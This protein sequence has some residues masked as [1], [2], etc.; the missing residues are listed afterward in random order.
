MDVDLNGLRPLED[1]SLRSAAA[2]SAQLTTEA[3]AL[4]AEC[5]APGTF[6]LRFAASPDQ[7]GPDYGLL[8]AKPSPPAQARFEVDAGVFRLTA[9]E[10]SLEL[11]PRPVRLRLVRGG[12][13]LLESTGDG[14]IRGGLRIPALATETGGEAWWMALGLSSC[15]PVYG[16]GEKF[17]PL[18]RRSQLIVSWNEDALGT[19]TERSYKNAPFAWSPKGWGVFVHTTAR[20]VHGVGYPQWSQRS[21]IVRV[22][23]PVLDVF[24][25]TG[26]SPAEILERYTHLVGRPPLLPRWSYGVWMSRC[27]YRTA[28]EAMEAAR[29]LRERR[30]PADVLVLDGRAWLKVET[31][32]AFEWDR[33]RYP[34]PAAFAR[35]LRALNFRLCVW[36]YP[37][38][39]VHHPLFSELA[40]KGYL[41]RTGQGDPYVY[42]WDPGPFGELLTPL[43]PSGMVDFTN[44]EAYAW[45]RD[46]HQQLFAHGV[47]VIKTDFG[48]QVPVDALAANG[49]GGARLHNA[50]PL[51]YNRCVFEATAKHAPGGALVWGRSGWAGSQR[52]PIQWG[53]DPQADWEGLAA[54]IRGGLSWGASGV[55]FYS[56]DIGGFY[57]I[58]PGAMPDTELYIRWTQAGVMAS[59][60][61]FHGTSPREPWHY[62]QAAEDIVRRW[63]EWRYRLIPYLEACAFE[64]HRTGLP[65]MRA[66]PIAMPDDPASWAFEHQYLLGPSLLVAPVIEPGGVV[67][68]YLP[69]GGWCDLNNGQWFE[70][71]AVLER[72]VPLDKMPVYGREGHML[73]LGPVVQH[74]GELGE[75]VQLEELWLFGTP[76]VGVAWPDLGIEPDLR[77]VPPGVRVRRW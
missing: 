18:N 21:Y 37:Y 67:H 47:D 22:A 52:Y 77:G 11:I 44:P 14:H 32:F 74:T 5:Y 35:Q 60:T 10:V 55:P 46:A 2:A 76:Q 45:Y 19:N 58:T 6:R 30:I 27:Y 41:L 43:P 73:P 48:E 59:H 26:A 50:Y 51:L 36:E 64:A 63:L 57:H 71:P 40:K 13:T 53:G 34:D 38:V 8:S 39:S 23:D 1:L 25:V 15:E 24:L 31:R 4:A 12:S 65:V 75:G 33:Q 62:G 61:R 49:D 54:S 56:H 28:D 9:G 17:G 69:A 29:G 42:Q 70:G 66:M 7:A 72:A 16:L 20:V 3:A 68:L